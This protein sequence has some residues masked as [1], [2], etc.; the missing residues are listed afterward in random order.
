[1]LKFRGIGGANPMFLPKIMELGRQIQH[2][3][4]NSWNWGAECHG[5]EK[6]VEIAGQMP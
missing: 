5:M 3:A 2:S 1:M 4:N 6:L